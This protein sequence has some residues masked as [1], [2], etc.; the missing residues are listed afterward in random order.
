MGK[1]RFKDVRLFCFSYTGLDVREGGGSVAGNCDAVSLF[2]LV[3]MSGVWGDRG[4]FQIAPPLSKGNQVNIPEP[5]CGYWG[6]ASKTW[7]QPCSSNIGQGSKM[8][9]R[10]RIRRRQ[11]EPWEELSFLFN[12][13]EC[14]GIRLPGDR[15]QYSAKHC[16]SGGVRC[17][18]DGP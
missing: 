12:A 7:L 16:T 9:Q 10:K 8:R 5:G 14:P 17:A 15:A 11:R 4:I 18:L 6:Q 3:S 13:V 2:P 1:L